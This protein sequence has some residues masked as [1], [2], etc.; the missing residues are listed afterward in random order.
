MLFDYCHA[1]LDHWRGP[2]PDSQGS[3]TIDHLQTTAR[4]QGENRTRDDIDGM[5]IYKL[6]HDLFDT[7]D[8]KSLKLYAS[9]QR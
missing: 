9:K 3:S 1:I 6:L 4:T 2:T 8:K 5:R 7:T